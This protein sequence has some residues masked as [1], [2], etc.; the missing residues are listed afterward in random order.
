M[1]ELLIQLITEYDKLSVH[2]VKGDVSFYL[3]ARQTIEKDYTNKFIPIPPSQIEA[4]QYFENLIISRAEM[5]YKLEAEKKA[6]HI[7]SITL[8]IIKAEI[9][10]ADKEGDREQLWKWLEEFRDIREYGHVAIMQWCR[11]VLL[12]ME[13][14]EVYPSGTYMEISKRTG[15]TIGLQRISDK[16]NP[17]FKTPVLNTQAVDAVQDD[18]IVPDDSIERPRRADT[19]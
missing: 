18:E 4:A 19:E 5:Y 11:E 12:K 13:I 9:S 6:I 8:S 1:K 10:K 7:A 14:L 16:A 17:R 15:E 3:M 2:T